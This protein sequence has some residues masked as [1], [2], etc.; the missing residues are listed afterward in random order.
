MW[1]WACPFT[2]V[3]DQASHSFCLVF[4]QLNVESVAP[5][6]HLEM[7]ARCGNRIVLAILIAIHGLGAIVPVSCFVMR[8]REL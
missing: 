7:S 5:N 3:A 1:V 4:R 2:A 8:L 6:N